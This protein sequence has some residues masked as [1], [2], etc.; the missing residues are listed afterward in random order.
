MSLWTRTVNVFRGD[1][2][3]RELNE[4]FESHIEEAIAAGSDPKD[5]RKTFGSML[6]QREASRRVRVVGWLDGLCADVIIIAK[7][8]DQPSFLSGRGRC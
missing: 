6:R 3:N 5:A 1:R 7:N 8:T 2:L 4:E